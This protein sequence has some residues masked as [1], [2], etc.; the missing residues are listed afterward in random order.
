KV[1]AML[2][3]VASA[4]PQH[5]TGTTPV[6][7]PCGGGGDRTK[8]GFK[9]PALDTVAV[10]T[11]LRWVWYAARRE[12]LHLDGTNYDSDY[13]AL[14]LTRGLLEKALQTVVAPALRLSPAD[15][16]SLFPLA[17]L[18]QYGAGETM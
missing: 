9:S 13:E 11:F 17:R 3:R 18:V 15:L 10:S 2:S 4:L 1:S 6:S 5:M 8:I 12:G 16:R 14:D 7:G